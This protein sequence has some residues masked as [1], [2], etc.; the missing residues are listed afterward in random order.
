M[1]AGLMTG[2]PSLGSAQDTAAGNSF[3]TP[4]P[5]G[6]TYKLLLIGDAMADGLV[7]GLTEAMG[8]D[9][10]LVINRKHRPLPG[11]F[12]SDIDEELSSLES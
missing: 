6:D 1:P 5:A 3:I 4:F 8:T 7:G 10:Q 2:L 12:R 9:T 11:L